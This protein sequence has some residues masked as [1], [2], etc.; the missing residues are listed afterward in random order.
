MEQTTNPTHLLA[1]LGILSSFS[2]AKRISNEEILKTTRKI[3]RVNKEKNK[4]KFQQLLNKAL[5][6]NAKKY[7]STKI[8][9]GLIFPHTSQQKELDKFYK[10][11]SVISETLCNKFVSQNLTKHQVCYI[12]ESIISMLGLKEE[13]FDDFHKKYSEYRNDTDGEN[14]EE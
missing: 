5:I 4:K 12:I 3:N 1:S 10:E 8:P 11:L 9:P 7:V 6:E 14:E 13:D 2:I